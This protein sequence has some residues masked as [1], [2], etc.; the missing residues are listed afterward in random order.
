MCLMSRG[1]D[2]LGPRELKDQVNSKHHLVSAD[3]FPNS[4]F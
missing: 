2:G 4:C 3:V 1:C